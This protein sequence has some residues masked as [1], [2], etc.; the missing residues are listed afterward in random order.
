MIIIM[1]GYIMKIKN[2]LALIGLGALATGVSVLILKS[3]ETTDNCCTK[4]DIAEPIEMPPNDPITSDTIN[5]ESIHLSE[6]KEQAS[7]AISQ[8][9]Q[10]AS[11]IMK[12]I[13]DDVFHNNFYEDLEANEKELDN[14]NNML[15]QSQTEEKYE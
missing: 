10:K 6:I 15:S 2:I 8:K 12:K 14:I 1:G 3:H 5:K 7:K 11:A 4:T 9:H 13:A